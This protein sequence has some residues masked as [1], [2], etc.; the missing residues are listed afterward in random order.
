MT[1]S[2]PWRQWL[3]AAKVTDDPEGDFI[4]DSRD[5][6][7]MPDITTKAELRQYL[8]TRQACQEAMDAVP[9]VWRRFEQWRRTHCRDDEATSSDQ[10]TKRTRSGEAFEYDRSHR[11]AMS[12]SYPDPGTVKFQPPA[13]ADIERA[14]RWLRKLL[15]LGPIFQGEVK[16][17][18]EAAGISG[19][20]L[21]AARKSLRVHATNVN[22]KND[23]ANY[24]VWFWSLPE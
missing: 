14:T 6:A 7:R 18:S 12:A 21:A 24:K 3:A 22:D 8:R 4:V 9:E 13:Q 11:S 20:V 1:D 17:L 23:L 16:F 10:E 2:S 15:K 5:D 19:S